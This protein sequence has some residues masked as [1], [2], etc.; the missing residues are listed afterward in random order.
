[1]EQTDCINY[2]IVEKININITLNQNK[3]D[4]ELLSIGEFNF[5]AWH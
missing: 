5:W 2:E 3:T 4:F 1:M